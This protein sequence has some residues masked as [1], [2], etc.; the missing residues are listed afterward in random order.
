M[1]N[2]VFGK[3]E[4][5]KLQF[6]VTSAALAPHD[7]FI[8]IGANL[9]G[10]LGQSAFSNCKAAVEALRGL[11][12]LRL[13]GVSPWY[14]TA[15]IPPGAP[16]YV[17]GVAW[18]VGI[19]DPASL[20]ATLQRIETL[21]AR[22][23]SVANAPRTLDLDIIAMGQTIRNAPDPILPHPRAHLR[24]FV[25]QPLCDLRPDWLHP[26]LGQRAIEILSGLPVQGIERLR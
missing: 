14:Q 5:L 7:V 12:G 10:P 4:A 11:N 17:N 25:M 26:V 21:G 8:A 16:P 3:L 2:A 9:P 19:V 13:M 20:L 15:S 6:Y 18:L 24:R 22:E 1:L 23:R